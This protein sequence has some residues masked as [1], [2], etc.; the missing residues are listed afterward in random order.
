M[1]YLL[2]FATY[3]GYLILFTIYL[4]QFRKTQ[5]ARQDLVD[6]DTSQVVGYGEFL[7]PKWW[8]ADEIKLFADLHCLPWNESGWRIET[9]EVIPHDNTFV[10]AKLKD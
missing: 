10:L 9:L 8:D 5:K 2:I 4:R 3:S 6:W 1:I 7:V